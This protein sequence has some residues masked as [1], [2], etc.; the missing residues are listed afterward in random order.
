MLFT[1]LDRLGDKHQYPNVIYDLLTY[2]Q[3]ADLDGF[4][5]GSHQYLDTDIYINVFEVNSVENPT[6]DRQS[7][8]HKDNID[9]QISVNGHEVYGFSPFSEQNILTEDRL[10]TEDS[11]LYTGIVD[12]TE[13]K[14]H[15]RDVII[16]FPNDLHRAYY[17]NQ[18][19]P[20]S[21]RIVAKVPVSLL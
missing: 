5:L 20:I 14:V 4:E 8:R 7:E 16:F 11:L 6:S 2:F 10:E 18:E 21:R 9:V 1:N 13:I 12:E 3:T 19:Q 17:Q 15:P